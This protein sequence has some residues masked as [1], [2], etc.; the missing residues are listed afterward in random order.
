M[1]VRRQMWVFKIME[2][3]P[4]NSSSNLEK[5]PIFLGILERIN[6][7]RTLSFKLRSSIG[8]QLYTDLT[9]LGTMEVDFRGGKT[10][11]FL[12]KISGVVF[13]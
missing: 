7:N 10:N 11:F 2:E 3:I 12:G 13:L 6:K 5:A 4:H 8:R 9:C 1:S